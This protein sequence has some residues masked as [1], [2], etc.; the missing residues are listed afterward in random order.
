MAPKVVSYGGG[1]Q[2]TALLVLAAQCRIEYKTFVFCNVGDDSENPATLDYVRNV[3]MPYAEAH[4]I[5]LIELRKE[6]ADGTPRTLWSVMMK[7]ESKSV[8]IPVF[9][10]NG[11]PS[12][13]TCT[14]GYKVDV[15]VKWL[16]SQGATK[17]D[18]GVSALGISIDE[19]QRMR[20]DSGNPYNRLEYPLIDMR[21]SRND[22]RKIIEDAG[23]PIPAKSACFFCPYTRITD[24]QRMKRE[25]PDLFEKSVEL[26]TFIN[27]RRAELGKLPTYLTRY[28]QPLEEVIGDQTV[29]DFD[30]SCE[31]GYCMT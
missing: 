17:D 3:A 9:M 13:R 6:I 15:M 16:R 28:G 5:D 27:K 18:P 23:L 7:D 24:W 12:S 8:P 31:S 2:S 4:G 29:F 19:F 14:M 30:D 10:S 22:C 20:T 11:S 25:T 21:L 1:V 26:E